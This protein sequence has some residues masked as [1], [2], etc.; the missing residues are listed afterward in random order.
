MGI[1]L[2]KV[3]WDDLAFDQVADSHLVKKLLTQTMDEVLIELTRDP[4]YLYW[5][6]LAKGEVSTQ[7]IEKIKNYSER[8]ARFF[9]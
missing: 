1:V 5:L 6:R 7:T 8:Q 4:H 9:S 2:N 3:K